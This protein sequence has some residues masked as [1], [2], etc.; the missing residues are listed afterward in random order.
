[1]IHFDVTM[2]II[3]RWMSDAEKREH[4]KEKGKKV[5]LAQCNFH[6]DVVSMDDCIDCK[7]PDKLLRIVR[8]MK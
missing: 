2:R 6:N 7:N 3:C 4:K 5:W 8:L 1:M